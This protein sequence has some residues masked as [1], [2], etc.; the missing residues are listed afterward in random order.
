MF[1]GLILVYARTSFEYFSNQTAAILPLSVILP[2]FS[3]RNYKALSSGKESK[4]WSRMTLGFSFIVSGTL[5]NLFYEGFT[6]QHYLLAS[7]A[8]SFTGY[9]FITWAILK[10]VFAF[11]SKR[12]KSEFLKLVTVLFGSVFFFVLFLLRPLFLSH[13]IFMERQK[14]FLVFGGDMTLVFTLLLYLFKSP[15][16]GLLGKSLRMLTIGFL[17]NAA[18]HFLEFYLLFFAP[19]SEPLMFGAIF[20]EP[21]SFAYMAY[22][23]LR[24]R[25]ALS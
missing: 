2:F 20:L 17:I 23:M 16:G 4:F 13:L 9:V 12:A 14:F 15:F 18:S 19:H 11:R 3:Y 25:D 5:V 8:L 22:A 10:Q 1:L 7:E 24:Y 6:Q 21:L